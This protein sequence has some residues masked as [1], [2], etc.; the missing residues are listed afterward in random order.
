MSATSRI[1]VFIG[2]DE[3]KVGYYK[4]WDTEEQKLYRTRDVHFDEH[5]FSQ[6]KRH[7]NTKW[8][9]RIISEEPH[10]ELYPSLNHSTT[11]YDLCYTKGESESEQCQPVA[12]EDDDNDDLGNKHHSEPEKD[13]VPNIDLH[14][15]PPN[16]N[17]REISTQVE[18]RS[19]L[20]AFPDIPVSHFSLDP[21]S[22]LGL[23]PDSPTPAVTPLT[24]ISTS[25]II[26][27]PRARH[28][29]ALAVT[30]QQVP[31]SYQEAM[32]SELR[33]QWLKLRM[34]K[35]L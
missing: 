4:V 26:S 18:A 22:D 20:P 7:K 25:N 15:P 13:E 16:H 29:R 1:G 35:C 5:N 3:E 28:G 19:L 12:V 23:F 10:P 33:Q 32:T 27:G 34:M 2:Y 8:F 30:D 31:T 24:A 21:E 11:I 9:T 14:H 6:S 17:D